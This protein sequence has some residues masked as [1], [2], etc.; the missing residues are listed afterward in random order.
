[1]ESAYTMERQYDIGTCRNTLG[2]ARDSFFRCTNI[3]N[4]RLFI[5]I[6]QPLVGDKDID[7]FIL[8]N[9]DTSCPKSFVA[10]QR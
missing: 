4:P 7:Q 8:A 6:L 2:N 5:F 10:L 1:M 9:A 3:G